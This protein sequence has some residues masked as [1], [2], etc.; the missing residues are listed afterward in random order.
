MRGSVPLAVDDHIASLRLQ[1]SV[2]GDA[3]FR[4]KR[5]LLPDATTRWPDI[6]DSSHARNDGLGDWTHSLCQGAQD[7]AGCTGLPKGSRLR[8]NLR[9]WSRRSHLLRMPAC[10]GGS[11]PNLI[12]TL[13][14][15][16]HDALGFI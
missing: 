14:P 10:I 5:N 13:G 6:R 16:G 15:M 11:M 1:W 7:D 9:R 8:R 2:Q 12:T 3:S 4:R